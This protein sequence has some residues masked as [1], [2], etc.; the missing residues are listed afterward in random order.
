MFISIPKDCWVDAFTIQLDFAKQLLE[1]KVEAE[2]NKNINSFKHDG[3]TIE[4]LNWFYG[5][6]IKYDNSNYRIPKWWKD[7]SDLTLQDCLDIIWSKG[8]KKLPSK[9]AS[10]Y[11]S[12]K[13]RK[14]TKK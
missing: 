4:L 2:K 8:D 13:T 11:K 3:K 12:P 5:P 10:S 14:K 9:K 6:Y 7:A 1:K